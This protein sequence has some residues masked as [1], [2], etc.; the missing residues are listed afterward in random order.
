MGDNMITVPYGD[1][2]DGICAQADLS[3]IRALLK[4]GRAYCSEDI[5]AILGIEVAENDTTD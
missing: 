5:K 2:V 3:A 1:F 4:N